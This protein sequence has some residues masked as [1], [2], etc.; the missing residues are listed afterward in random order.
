MSAVAYPFFI[1]MI[2]A[3]VIFQWRWRFIFINEPTTWILELEQWCIS[4]AQMLSSSWTELSLFWEINHQANNR[5][6][7]NISLYLCTHCSSR[8]ALVVR[9]VSWASISAYTHLCFA[10]LHPNSP[11]MYN[12][13]VLLHSTRTW[14][15]LYVR[16]LAY[17]YCHCN[18]Y[19]SFTAW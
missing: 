15:Y 19:L 17:Y 16:F 18:F 5:Q 6:Y 2:I 10:I 4:K 1:I 7:V 13:F 12:L 9:M 3:R 8:I 14:F 11:I